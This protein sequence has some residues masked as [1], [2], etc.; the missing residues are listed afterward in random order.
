M[1]RYAWKDNPVRANVRTL[2]GIPMSSFQLNI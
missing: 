2:T 1:I